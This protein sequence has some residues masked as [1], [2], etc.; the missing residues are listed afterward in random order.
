M[1]RSRAKHR[2]F[3]LPAL[4]ASTASLA[5]G[6]VGVSV[7]TACYSQGD[8]ADP[9]LDQLYFPVGLQVSHGGSVLYVANSDF[10][11]QY[12]GGTLQSYDLALVRRHA[13]DVIANP[14]NPALPWVR[15]PSTYAGLDGG[16]FDCTNPPA[17]APS[18]S[19]Q[20]LG[21][22]CAPP[23]RSA[24]YHRDT[25]VIGAFATDML[26]S[27][28]PVVGPGVA[29]RGY[30][31]LF[32]PVR[33]NATLTWANVVRDGF[34]TSPPAS[35]PADRT[36]ALAAYAPW[37]VGCEQTPDTKRCSARHQVGEDPDE[38]GNTRKLRMPGEPFGIA[39]SE[40]GRSVLITHQNETKT[41]LFL[42]GLGPNDASSAQAN[43]ATETPPSIQFV[44]DGV[45]AGG[46]GLA[47]IPHDP[48][49]F[50]NQVAPFPA[51]L[52]TSRARAEV[53][54]LRQYPDEATD[55]VR[56]PD[57][58]TATNTGAVLTPSSLRRPFLTREAAFPITVSP[59]AVDSRGIVIDPSPRLA[60]QAKLDK[61][62][63]GTDEQKLAC[64]RR[65]SR[66]FITNRAPAS[67][68]IGEVGGSNAATGIYD[69]DLLTIFRSEPLSAG[70]SR[71][72]VAP[73]VDKD[74]AYALRVF[75]VCFDA[76]QIFVFDPDAGILENVIRVGPGPFAM[77]FD[78]FDAKE[79][80]S[81]AVVPPD[82]RLGAVNTRYRFAYVAS[83]TQS[84]VQ[85][86]D[87]DR[88]KPGTFERVVFTLGQPT[89][90]KGT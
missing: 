90:P 35:V 75:V 38:Q 20:P 33:G 56:L 2:A 84:F 55:L 37:A 74:G 7:G 40:D 89:N 62:G 67:L 69:P 17:S 60:C 25:A 45:A 13:L 50:G 88:R 43:A 5:I 34:D 14:A 19:R 57:G 1:G 78:P 36:Q 54:L 41:S 16:V 51:F 30:D 31:R 23:V 71:V 28:A 8:G 39:L 3:A 48:R 85:L 44:L 22:T 27:D 42:T 87:L 70:P 18:G 4:L 10:D 9:P 79:V 80:A 26:L 68:L 82:P 53:E 52:Q 63:G 59:S 24:F 77:A 65:P 72:Y 29:P 83:F 61:A 81:H 76:A 21:E 86:L 66:V 47:A 64:A 49:A 58:G 12:N 11:L 46:V 73:I 15:P 32:V 6:L